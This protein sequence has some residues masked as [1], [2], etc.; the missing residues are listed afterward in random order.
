MRKLLIAALLFLTSCS[1]QESSATG[2]TKT[3][4]ALAQPPL[5]ETLATGV[6]AASG[7]Q[8]VSAVNDAT[9]SVVPP[10]QTSDTK[11]RNL[12]RHRGDRHSIGIADIGTSFDELVS[13]FDCD[14]TEETDGYLMVLLNGQTIFSLNDKNDLQDKIVRNVVISSPTISTDGG[15]HVGMSVKELQRRF[16][17]LELFVDYEDNVE[18][19][20]PP[21][22]EKGTAK[23]QDAE[24]WIYVTTNSDGIL[25]Q[26]SQ[27]KYPTRHFSSEGTVRYI[28]VLVTGNR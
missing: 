8:S 27:G 12:G 10:T 24:V 6:P 28:R 20:A 4:A 13:H 19:F 26:D 16:P 9:Q 17:N 21:S 18:Y 14:S 1:G 5:T 2:V 15:I 11:V 3:R 23:N 25:S 22:L 7:G